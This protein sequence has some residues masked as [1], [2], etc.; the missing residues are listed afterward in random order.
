M[1]PDPEDYLWLSSYRT[2][3]VDI[4]RRVLNWKAI[5]YGLD[6][7]QYKNKN[8]L[9]GAILDIY[10]R[11]FRNDPEYKLRYETFFGVKLDF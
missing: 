5:S 7:D 11:D 3:Y 1:E 8:L 6:P 2:G 4:K 10:E 9:I